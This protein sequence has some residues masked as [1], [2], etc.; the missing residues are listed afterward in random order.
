MSSFVCL[1]SYLFYIQI[2]VV[3]LVLLKMYVGTY[4][5]SSLSLFSYQKCVYISLCLLSQFA[6]CFDDFITWVDACQ[7]LKKKE[8]KKEKKN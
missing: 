5:T 6:F 3:I 8:N 7:N 4:E 2:S 1:I